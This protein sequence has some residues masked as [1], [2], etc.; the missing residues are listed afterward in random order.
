[1]SY[2]N[3][4]FQNLSL[5]PAEMIAAKRGI[6]SRVSN[7]SERRPVGSGSRNHCPRN[8]ASRENRVSGTPTNYASVPS[9]D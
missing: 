8:F 5:D 1:M 6:R 3:P 2:V 7:A 9:M 4:P